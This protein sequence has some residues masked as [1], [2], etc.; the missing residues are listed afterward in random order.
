VETVDG[1]LVS[2]I[3]AKRTGTEL[4]LR[5]AEDKEIRIAANAVVSMQAQS[6]SSMPEMLLRDLTAQQA[7]DL[8][9][10]LA[11]LQKE[12]ARDQSTGGR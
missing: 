11:S 7:V 6:V 9:D 4:V 12:S 1:K 10:Y 5:S 2:G 3:L 8:I